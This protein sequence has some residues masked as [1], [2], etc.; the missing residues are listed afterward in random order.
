[1]KVL[2]EYFKDFQLMLP[3]TPGGSCCLHPE[4]RESKLSRD[5]NNKLWLL[6]KELKDQIELCVVNEVPKDAYPYIAMI[7]YK[8]FESAVKEFV[9]KISQKP[10]G[11][12]RPKENFLTFLV[13][14]LLGKRTFVK[15]GPYDDIKDL[16]QKI[17]TIEEKFMP[18]VTFTEDTN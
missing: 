18:L 1:M 3:A 10:M 14:Y 16:K 15:F 11:I 9:Y 8:R 5:L 7:S 2:I 12:I 17:S 13:K 4:V 6:K